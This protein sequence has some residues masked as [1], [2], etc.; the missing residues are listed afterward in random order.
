MANPKNFCHFS[1]EVSSELKFFTNKSGIDFAAETYL[2]VERNYRSKDGY[3]L[4]D[5]IHIRFEGENIIPF[6]KNNINKGD[7]LDVITS[8]VTKVINDEK[9]NSRQINYF[10]IGD[11]KLTKGSEKNN[12]TS[13]T[14]KTVSVELPFDIGL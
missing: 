13:E 7:E 5:Y 11:F 14:S 10:Q 6:V 12:K 4:Y 1:G 8:Y 2:K 3:Y 9:G